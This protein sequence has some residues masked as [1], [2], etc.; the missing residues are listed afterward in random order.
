M[1]CAY[2]FQVCHKSLS[3]RY[4]HAYKRAC[5]FL[6]PAIPRC[7]F[8]LFSQYGRTNTKSIVS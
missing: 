8:V 5:N 7:I 4:L 1:L 3:A 2:T 6:R